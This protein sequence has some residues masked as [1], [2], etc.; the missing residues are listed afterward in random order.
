MVNKELPKKDF[1]STAEIAKVLGLSRISVFNRIKKGQ[2]PAQKVGR[3]YVI[4]RSYLEG[5]SD[6]TVTDKQRGFIEKAVKQTVH[7]YG[8]TLKQ[9][10]KE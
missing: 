7:E 6:E 3:S 5:I 10:G 9:L 2:I 8:V 1:F 4:P